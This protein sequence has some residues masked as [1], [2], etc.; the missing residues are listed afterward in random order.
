MLKPR[1]K[2]IEFGVK[3]L[4][5]HELIAILIGSGI[6]GKDVFSISKKVEK[7]ILKIFNTD[8]FSIKEFQVI[9]GVGKVKALRI[10]S[11]LELGKRIYSDKAQK[12]LSTRDVWLLTRS[13]VNGG[14]ESVIALYLNGNNQLIDSLEIARGGIN[15]IYIDVRLLLKKAIELMSSGII[16]VHNHPS[17]NVKPSDS[18]IVTTKTVRSAC[19]L[20]GIKLIDHVV[21]TS[22]SFCSINE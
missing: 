7:L 2:L 1:E 10:L 15:S 17:G 14:N 20:M 9:K 22:E 12:L 13:I 8:S 4:S 19:E 3:S 21:V 11:A 18:D 16:L 6:E 5:N